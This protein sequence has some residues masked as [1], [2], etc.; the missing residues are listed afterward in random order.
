MKKPALLFV[1]LCVVA[2]FLIVPAARSAPAPTAGLR[3]G[4]YD[5]RA[6]A[7]AYW[8]SEEGMKQLNGLKA[9]MAE[10][11]AAGDE[12]RVAELEKEGP[13]LQVRLHQ[14][15][16]S[17]GCISDVLRKIEAELP[18][19]AEQAGVSLLV[20]KWE[21]AFKG[22]DV[23]CVDVTRTLVDL[24]SP[25]EEVLEMLPEIAKVQP[26]PIDELPM[27]PDCRH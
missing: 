25:N 20:S 23:E 21:I 10:A 12:K 3:I 19:I 26:V 6:V 24:F 4:T 17:T 13:G 22:A 15:V 5:S 8:R 11:K 18:A 27:D 9:E 2:S 7:F 1:A 14:Q 16:F